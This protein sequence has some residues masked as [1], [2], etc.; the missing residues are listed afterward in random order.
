[1]GIVHFFSGK[2]ATTE[3]RRALRALVTSFNKVPTTPPKR[4]EGDR[5]T[6]FKSEPDPTG[7]KEEEEVDTCKSKLG[8]DPTRGKEAIKTS[9]VVDEGKILAR[10][11]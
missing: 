3:D 2:F 7:F 5:A 8:E 4:A 1:L 6:T 9:L 11:D 10:P